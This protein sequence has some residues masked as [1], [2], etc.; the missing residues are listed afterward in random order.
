MIK[1]D[2][3]SYAFCKQFYACDILFA[4]KLGMDGV[5]LVETNDT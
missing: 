2:E 5:T 1:T 4:E 3:E